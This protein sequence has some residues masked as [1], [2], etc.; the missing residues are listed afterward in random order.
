M[1]SNTFIFKVG[2]LAIILK[3]ILV[4]LGVD[5]AKRDGTV[6]NNHLQYGLKSIVFGL[7]ILIVIF[8]YK[9]EK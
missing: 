1:K 9:K 8:L 6:I 3:G 5:L 7:I 4:L 2:G